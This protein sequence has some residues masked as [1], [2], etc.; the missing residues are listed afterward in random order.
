MPAD[1]KRAPLPTE[2]GEPDRNA[3]QAEDDDLLAFPNMRVFHDLRISLADWSA[4]TDLTDVLKEHGAKVDR[5]S[6]QTQQSGCVILC[7][8]DGLKPR[9]AM[10]AVFQIRSLGRTLS[11]N[12]EH[13]L[14]RR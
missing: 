7:R 5:L 3:I 9:A 4:L 11:A 2:P 14:L 6:L 8:I 13:L 10:A 1:M 12:I